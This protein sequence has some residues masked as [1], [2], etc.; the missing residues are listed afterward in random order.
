MG[1]IRPLVGG[2]GHIDI[3]A[4]VREAYIVGLYEDGEDK[5]RIEALKTSLTKSKYSTNNPSWAKYFDEGKRTNSL[6]QVDARRAYCL[7]YFVFPSSP[8]DGLHSFIFPMA[9]LLA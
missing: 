3:S 6:Y 8:K 4:T 5:K 1:E 9:V 2:L 7:S